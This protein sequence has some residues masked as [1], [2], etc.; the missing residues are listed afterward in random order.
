MFA[1]KLKLIES[2]CVSRGLDDSVAHA[3]RTRIV[4]QSRRIKASGSF[5]CGLLGDK[6]NTDRDHPQ[7]NEKNCHLPAHLMNSPQDPCFVNCSGRY[8]RCRRLARRRQYS[9]SYTPVRCFLF[10]RRITVSNSLHLSRGSNMCDLA[11]SSAAADPPE[12]RSVWIS[13]LRELSSLIR[14]R[15]GPD[16]AS[17]GRGKSRSTRR[18]ERIRQIRRSCPLR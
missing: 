6:C 16:R 11:R 9:G 14:W 8:P 1:L 2:E 3:L 10:P 17:V 4:T 7:R 18:T 13:Q 12:S 5:G 15:Y